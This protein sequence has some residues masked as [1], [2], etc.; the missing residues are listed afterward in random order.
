MT[1]VWDKVYQQWVAPD[2]I[3]CPVCHSCRLIVVGPRQGLCVHGTCG[4]RY[5]GYVEVKE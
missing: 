2:P 1:P 4:G 5:T 3:H